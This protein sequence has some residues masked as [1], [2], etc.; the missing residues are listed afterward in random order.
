METKIL[1]SCK[2]ILGESVA[3]SIGSLVV[4]SIGIL[5]TAVV[6]FSRGLSLVTWSIG[7]AINSTFLG[8]NISPTIDAPPPVKM[9][10]VGIVDT[11]DQ[12]GLTGGEAKLNGEPSWEPDRGMVGVAF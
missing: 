10:T 3:T 7:C 2:P 11:E 8:K 9:S 12:Y 4:G 6:A 5:L 1:N